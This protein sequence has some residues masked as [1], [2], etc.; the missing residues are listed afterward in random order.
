MGLC[1]FKN[2][3]QWILVIYLNLMFTA[4]VF[5]VSKEE[6]RLAFLGTTILLT[7]TP[8]ILVGGF[9]V[10]IRKRQQRLFS[11]KKT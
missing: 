2:K 7:L 9:I 5:G 4:P 11:N 8:L 6:S 10:F 1:I 3:F